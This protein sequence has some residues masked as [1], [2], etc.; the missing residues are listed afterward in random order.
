MTRGRGR[1]VAYLAT[2]MLDKCNARF[3]NGWQVRIGQTWV[4]LSD[5]EFEAVVMD[6]AE[7]FKLGTPSA[8]QDLHMV[9]KQRRTR[10]RLI[11]AMRNVSPGA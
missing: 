8:G 1:D 10:Q 5:S 9:S 6:R 11:W 2:W 7:Q 3:N 4:D